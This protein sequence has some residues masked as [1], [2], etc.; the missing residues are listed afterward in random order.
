[1]VCGLTEVGGLYLTSYSPLERQQVGWTFKLLYL[2]SIT[3]KGLHVAQATLLSVMW[4]PRWE[5][6]W[7]N[8]YMLKYG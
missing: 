6:N 8:R 7:E 4:Q 3:S 1:M 5:G 2:E